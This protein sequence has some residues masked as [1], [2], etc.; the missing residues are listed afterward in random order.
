MKS[1]DAVLIDADFDQT[2]RI[3]IEPCAQRL[4]RRRDGRVALDGAHDPQTGETRLDII[5]NGR[6]PAARH[7]HRHRERAVG[8]RDFGQ[9]GV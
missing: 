7:R 8:L 9:G 6:G 4:R 3:V 5:D 2:Y 1:A